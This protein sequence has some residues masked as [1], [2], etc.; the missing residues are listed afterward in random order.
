ML[1]DDPTKYAIELT[2][3]YARACR[4]IE[5]L[6]Y[7]E[8]LVRS[9]PLQCTYRKNR[10]MTDKRQSLARR[11]DVF[12]R[13]RIGLVLDCIPFV[14]QYGDGA[15]PFNGER[16]DFEILLSNADLGIDHQQNDVGAF[17][18]I[19]C[20]D[21]RK[22]LDLLANRTLLADTCRIDE[23]EFLTVFPLEFGV[24]R[25]ARRARNIGCQ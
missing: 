10:Y 18:G 7:I 13:R 15:T 11:R 6:R 9:R 23:H 16:G 4:R 20:L 2:R 21:D 8:D 19:E 25:V 24:D 12:R 17:D 5:F 14:E 1:L 22:F 3:R